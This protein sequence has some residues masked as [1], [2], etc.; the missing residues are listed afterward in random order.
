LAA[1]FLVRTF[2]TA[3]FC[4][5]GQISGSRAGQWGSGIAYDQPIVAAIFRL[6]S[7]RDLLCS[8]IFAGGWTSLARCVL[9]FATGWLCM[10]AQRFHCP[11]RQAWHYYSTGTQVNWLAPSSQ[12]P[13]YGNARQAHLA[14]LPLVS[15]ILD[16]GRRQWLLVNWAGLLSV[17][18]LADYDDQQPRLAGDRLIILTG[19]VR[20]SGT[21]HWLRPAAGSGSLGLSWQLS[22]GAATWTACLEL[23]RP[24]RHAAKP[25]TLWRQSLVG[26]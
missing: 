18:V 22:S 15:A 7:A 26:G 13:H 25:T 9:V 16:P 11:A 21:V 6:L 2:C 24:Y 14:A 4:A 20:I 5:F 8:S 17:V 12:A 1:A 10:A 19:L 23:C 3:A